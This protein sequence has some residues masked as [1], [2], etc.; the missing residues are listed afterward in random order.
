MPC[1]QVGAASRWENA[2]L[3]G[4]YYPTLHRVDTKPQSLGC[5]G[6][7][8]NYRQCLL[9]GSAGMVAQRYSVDCQS[10]GHM[11]DL[12]FFGS[13]QALA[14][15]GGFYFRV[16]PY[17][18]LS[19]IFQTTAI[20]MPVRISFILIVGRVISVKSRCWTILIYILR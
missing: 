6:I 18:I 11:S 19:R 20:P 17:I 4:T 8:V 16:F 14:S 3:G 15:M 2:F 5:C 7:R 10:R 1:S 13:E 12:K 9:A